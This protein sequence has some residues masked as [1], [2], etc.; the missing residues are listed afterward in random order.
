MKRIKK[1]LM[2]KSDRMMWTWFL[3]QQILFWL[4]VPMSPVSCSSWVGERVTGIGL[5]VSLS[6]GFCFIFLMIR[7]WIKKTS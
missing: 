4:F 1:G 7:K 5:G 3:L 6:F 2:M